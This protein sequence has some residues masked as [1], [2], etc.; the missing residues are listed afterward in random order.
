[1]S[2]AV[3][4]FIAS[5]SHRTKSLFL[6]CLHRF[7]VAAVCVV[8][9][10]VVLVDVAAVVLLVAAAAAVVVDDDDVVVVATVVAADVV[11][12]YECVVRTQGLVFGQS[13][14]HP[15]SGKFFKPSDVCIHHFD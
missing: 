14:V 6:D 8:D 15:V 1:M 10:L 5:T 12:R 7:V 13:F 4:F 11:V 9:D 3:I 2:V